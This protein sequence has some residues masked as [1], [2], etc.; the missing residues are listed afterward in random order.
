MEQELSVSLSPKQAAEAINLDDP[1][2]LLQYGAAAQS[3]I[4]EFSDLALRSFRDKTPDNINE[5]M[6]DLIT[7]LEGFSQ[8]EPEGTFRKF[9]YRPVKAVHAIKT[10]YRQTSENIDQI[11]TRLQEQQSLLMK[12]IELLEQLYAMNL[13]HFRELEDYVEEGTKKLTALREEDLPELIQQAKI[14]GRPDDAQ[15]AKDFEDKCNRFEQ[16]IQDLILTRTVALQMAPQI[17]MIQNNDMLL[18]EKIRSSIVNTVPLWKSQMVLALGMEN[19]KEAL[20]IQGQVDNLTNRLL[21]LN[22]DTLK[23]CT[24][25]TARQT[26]QNIVET[27]TLRET[28]RI[29]ISTLDEVLK[30][31]EEGQKQRIAA[32]GELKKMEEELKEKLLAGTTISK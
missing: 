11:V 8:T 24:V 31:R 22:A 3:K 13:E 19:S 21:R 26:E 1:S 32:Q 30:I 20:R 7:Q 23:A 12:D 5:M 15:R 18:A 25:Q 28:N 14:S 29:L 16:K 2:T 9:L 4:A 10:K 27:E 6:T 17:R